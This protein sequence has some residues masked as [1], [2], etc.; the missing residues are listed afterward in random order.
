MGG[1]DE[2]AMSREELRSAMLRDAAGMRGLQQFLAGIKDLDDA[3]FAVKAVDHGHGHD[4][5]GIGGCG[6]H[7]PRRSAALG[8]D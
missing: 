3:A 4:P 8:P 2:P 6:A 7:G 1:A 5:F